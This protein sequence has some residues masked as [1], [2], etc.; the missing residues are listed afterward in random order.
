MHFHLFF[1]F[2]PSEFE[3]YVFIIYQDKDNSFIQLFHPS[4]LFFLQ[5]MLWKEKG[6]KDKWRQNN[7]AQI[8]ME[9]CELFWCETRQ[10]SYILLWQFSGMSLYV[11]INSIDTY[12]TS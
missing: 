7:S 8:F 1:E 4:Y 5:Y 3:L 11:G 10:R 2:S 6:F 12:N 9:L